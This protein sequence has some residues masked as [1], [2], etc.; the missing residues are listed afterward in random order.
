[1]VFAGVADLLFC[2]PE[3]VEENFED[4]IVGVHDGER[5]DCLRLQGRG[6]KERRC[7]LPRCHGPRTA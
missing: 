5:L 7:A 6:V 2:H 4:L 1:M 3:L